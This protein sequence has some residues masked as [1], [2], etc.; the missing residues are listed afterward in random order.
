MM[1]HE[2]PT[3]RRHGISTTPQLAMVSHVDTAS[4]KHDTNRNPA[5][6]A[7]IAPSACVRF[8]ALFACY[9]LLHT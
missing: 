5:L 2:L 3:V 4:P 8:H 7:H 9:M 6:F 1:L